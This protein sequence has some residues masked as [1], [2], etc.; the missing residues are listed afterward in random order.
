MTRPR[1]PE[2]IPNDGDPA[3]SNFITVPGPVSLTAL[4]RLKADWHH[5][6]T[7]YITPGASFWVLLRNRLLAVNHRPLPVL[8]DDSIIPIRHLTPHQLRCLAYSN[9]LHEPHYTR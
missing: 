3:P 2:I 7:S 6:A 8:Y 9:A 5:R 1:H 4:A